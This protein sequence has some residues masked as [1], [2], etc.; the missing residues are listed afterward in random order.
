MIRKCFRGLVVPLMVALTAV[1]CGCNPASPGN[2]QGAANASAPQPESAAPVAKKTAPQPA[3]AAP[4]AKTAAPQAPTAP[5]AA[6]LVVPPGNPEKKAEELTQA[7][8]PAKE[9]VGPR[10]HSDEPVFDFGR[11][12]NTQ[13]VEH[14]F[15]V[16]N[17]GDAPLELGKIKTSCGCTVAK[18]T[19]TTLQPGEET[20]IHATLSLKGKEGTKT[21]VVTVPSNDPQ[22]PN[23]Q[24][25]F[26]GIAVA[27]IRV[28]PYSLNYGQVDGD[29]QVEDRFLTVQAVDKDVTFKITNT[30]CSSPYFETSVEEV[31]PGKSYKITVKNV[32]PL[33]EGPITG[34]IRISTDDPARPQ[35]NVSVYGSVV[36]DIVVVPSRI[37]VHYNEDPG[38]KTSQYIRVAAG[39]VKEFEITEVISPLDEVQVEFSP[40][41][42]KFSEYLIKLTN[43]PANGVLDGKELIIKT[44]IP[45]KPEIR[46]PFINKKTTRPG[47]LIR[48]PSPTRP[49]SKA[50]TVKK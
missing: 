35:F 4:V 36:G 5:V 13:K 42:A 7:A 22:T 19:K 34:R 24:L 37:S 30:E 6:P 16:K 40:R 39:K 8:V 29:S 41:K 50:K 21:T 48:R 46:V 14:D 47:S 1:M 25:K 17:T 26:T 28:K 32:K 2:D 9:S 18:L 12:D 33:K 23:Y 31:L 15:V 20:S 10:V 27:S 45:G 43:M 38:R 44:N 11:V 49:L 3:S